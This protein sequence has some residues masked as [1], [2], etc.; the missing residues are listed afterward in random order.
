MVTRGSVPENSAAPAWAASAP[1]VPPLA[2][3]LAG[4]D[5]RLARARPLAPVHRDVGVREELGRA[6]RV[7]R[8]E[9]DAGAGGDAKRGAGRDPGLGPAAPRTVDDDLG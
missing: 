4:E 5:G 8:V 6:V 2:D 7:G 9:A 1:V 3:R